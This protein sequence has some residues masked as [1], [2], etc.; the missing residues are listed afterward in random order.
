[1][2]GVI[3]RCRAR[4]NPWLQL[5]VTQT[6]KNR[7]DWT[8]IRSSNT[9]WHLHQG[10]K[11]PTQKRH[12][13]SS[14]HRRTIHDSPTL[15][16]NNRWLHKNTMVYLVH[17]H[18]GILPGI[19]KRWSHESAVLW[20][21]LEKNHVWSLQQEQGKHRMFLSHMWVT[22]RNSRETTHVQR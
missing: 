2:P 14:V 18:N 4:N 22:K 13:H 17:L 15:V 16:H 11:I 8:F 21:D 20:M 6:N 19:K 3:P 10:A 5:G 7:G 1:M 12:L 9:S